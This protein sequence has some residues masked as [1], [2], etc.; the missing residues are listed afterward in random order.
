MKHILTLLLVVMVSALHA[1]TIRLDVSYVLFNGDSIVGPTTEI[2][3]NG[4]FVTSAPAGTIITLPADTEYELRPKWDDDPYNGVSAFD[5]YLIR[6]QIL[7]ITNVVN[8]Y[9][10]QAMDVNSS[11]AVSTLDL[12]ILR[13]FLLGSPLNQAVPGWQFVRADGIPVPVTVS[14][15]GTYVV[16]YVAIKIGDVDGSATVTNP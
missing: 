10:L 15:E 2:F 14:Q 1:Q 12:L 11:G 8:S 4:E 5:L 16:Q 9:V 3:A 13:K 6:K 7:G